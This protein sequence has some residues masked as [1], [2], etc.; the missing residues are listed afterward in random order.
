MEWSKEPFDDVLAQQAAMKIII[1]SLI[2]RLVSERHRD[3]A[4]RAKSITLPKRQNRILPPLIFLDFSG[5]SRA[6][7]RTSQVFRNLL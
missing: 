6:V 4:V 7:R 2:D 1:G 3:G 5:S